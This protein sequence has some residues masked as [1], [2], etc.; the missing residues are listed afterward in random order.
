MYWNDSNT[1]RYFG[2]LAVCLLALM[3]IIISLW[4]LKKIQKRH[5]LIPIYLFL[6][7]VQIQV[8]EYTVMFKINQIG[9][10][11]INKINIG[12]FIPI[13][14]IT[15]SAIQY[16]SYASRKTRRFIVL[17]TTAHFLISIATWNSIFQADNYITLS[18]TLESAILLIP[19][20]L[21][22]VELI[23]SPPTLQLN[24]EPSFWISTGILFFVIIITPFTLI[25][26]II[27]FEI[28][29]TLDFLGYLILIAL[30]IKAVICSHQST[31]T[32]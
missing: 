7:I 28:R 14:L 11:N 8:S 18:S 20:V 21:Y 32:G 30:F 26:P 29:Q 16:F 17:A 22:F 27:P 13:E 10:V 15:L 6:V 9:G 3:G 24:R 2:G 31:T 23:K 19:S 12:V 4:R 1:I 25:L 5:Y